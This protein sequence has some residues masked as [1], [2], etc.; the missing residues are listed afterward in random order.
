MLEILNDNRMSIAV[1]ERNLNQFGELGYVR[2]TTLG[3]KLRELKLAGLTLYMIE[4]IC[5][6]LDT[7]QDGFLFSSYFTD[8][9]RSYQVHSELKNI[10]LSVSWFQKEIYKTVQQFC[11]DQGIGMKKLKFYKG[12]VDED[13]N[14]EQ[15]IDIF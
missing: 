13:I 15:L 10:N 2:R 4:E 1:F 8:Y 9:L 6:L 12:K 5:E 11:I 14:I 7:A 3:Q